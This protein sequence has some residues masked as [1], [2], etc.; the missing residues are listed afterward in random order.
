MLAVITV[1]WYALEK[2]LSEEADVATYTKIFSSHLFK[3]NCSIAVC[4]SPGTFLA[5]A[6]TKRLQQILK[7][8]RNN[9]L[10]DL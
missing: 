10:N 1:W 9:A 6:L 7:H 2:D 5:D 4:L 3:G 8:A